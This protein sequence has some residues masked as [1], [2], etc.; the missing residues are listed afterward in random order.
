VALW[1]SWCPYWAQLHR[2]RK[3]M[4]ILLIDV[5]ICMWHLI[6]IPQETLQSSSGVKPSWFQNIDLGTPQIHYKV[7]LGQIWVNSEIHFGSTIIS[8]T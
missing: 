7:L 4:H 5:C 3:R 2:H 1:K 6:R 8:H